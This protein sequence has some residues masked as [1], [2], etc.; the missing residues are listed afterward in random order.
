MAKAGQGVWTRAI[1]DNLNNT[2]MTAGYEQ[3][4]DNRNKTGARTPLQIIDNIHIFKWK[5]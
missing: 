4:T 5:E 3:H 2:L 1:K